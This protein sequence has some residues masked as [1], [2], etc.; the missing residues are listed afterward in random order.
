MAKNGVRVAVHG[1][2]NLTA[3][4]LLVNGEQMTIDRPWS[5][6]DCC[7]GACPPT[8]GLVRTHWD[9]RAPGRSSSPA[10]TLDLLKQRPPME[11]PPANGRRLLVCLGGST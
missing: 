2:G 11:L 4:G 3:R 9:N 8:S 1:S 6:W 7:R 5:R 10:T